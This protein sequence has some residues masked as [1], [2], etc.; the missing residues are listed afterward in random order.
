MP[1]NPKKK[2]NPAQ[3]GYLQMMGESIFVLAHWHMMHS[4]G[5]EVSVLTPEV[6]EVPDIFIVSGSAK[7]K[8]RELYAKEIGR[9][10]AKELERL[11]FGKE[12]P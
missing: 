7:E 8:F 11:I 9:D 10:S 5:K 2:P 12:Q 4:T 1:R 6:N 3:C